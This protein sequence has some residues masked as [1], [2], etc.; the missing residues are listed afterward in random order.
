MAAPSAKPTTTAWGGILA[1]EKT[2]W[3][4]GRITEGVQLGRDLL[5]LAEALGDGVA[6]D[7]GLLV[8][9]IH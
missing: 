7:G 4:R 2:Q 3:H 1:Q 8:F 5:E 9:L 6:F